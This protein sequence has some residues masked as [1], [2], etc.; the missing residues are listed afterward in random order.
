MGYGV[1]GRYCN[2]REAVNVETTW[3]TM[4]QCGYARIKGLGAGA[5]FWPVPP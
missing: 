1:A 4:R 2:R 3:G 5:G